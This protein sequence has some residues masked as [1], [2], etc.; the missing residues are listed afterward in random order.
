MK[1]ILPV[2][3]IMENR[4]FVCA[5]LGY[6]VRVFGKDYSR[7][8]WH[9]NNLSNCEEFVNNNMVV[10]PRFSLQVFPLDYWKVYDDLCE[11]TFFAF[12]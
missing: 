11:L 4:Y 12:Y 7:Y 5:T 6:M 8:S 2:F 3:V 1:K 10:V 9:A